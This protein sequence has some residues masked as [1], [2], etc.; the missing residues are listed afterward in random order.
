VPDGPVREFFDGMHDLHHRA[1]WPS[2]RELAKEV[3]C[4]HTTVSVVFSQPSVPRWGLV[5]LIVEA[6]GGDTGR[7]HELWLAASS[8]T[9][10]TGPAAGSVPRQASIPTRPAP[11]PPP[12]QLPGDVTAFTGR[13]TQL[14]ELDRLLAESTFDATA[15]VILAVS[16]TA[17][18][19]KTALAV[20]WAHRVAKAFPDGQLYLNLRGYD[21]ERPVHVAEALERF[22]RA[23]GVEGTA[24]PHGLDERAAQY[25]TLL[26]DRKVLV[27]LDNA[28]SVDQ[29]RDLL[30]G[31]PSCLV[32]ITSRD[33]LPALVAR[34]GA[35][36]IN[37]DVL[38]STEAIELFRRLI[39]ERLDKEPDQAIVLARRCAR[40]PLAIRIAAELAAAR[41]SEPLWRLVAELGDESRRL[42]LLA[43][44]EDDY[45]AVRTVFSWSCRYLSDAAVTVFQLLGLHPGQDIDVDATAAL[46]DVDRTETRRLLEVLSRAHLVAENSPG[47]F[48][49]HDLL[50]AYAAEQAMTRTDQHTALLRLFDHYLR[51]AAR[52][53]E[54]SEAV[55]SDDQWLSAERSNLLAV[56]A[57]AVDVS[58]EHTVK[59]SACLARHLDTG[60]HYSDGVTLHRLALTASRARDDPTGEADSLNRLGFVQLRIGSYPEAIDH[61][62]QALAVHREIGS[63][64]GE[65]TARHGLG[66]VALRLGHC[67]EARDQ[68]EAA[69]TIR[70]ELGDRPGEGTALYGLGNVYRQLGDYQKALDHQ[71][72]ALTIYRECGERIGE[73]RVLNNLGTTMERL[74]NYVQALDHYER[75]LALNREIGNQLGEAVAL[76]NLGWTTARVGRFAEAI[77]H[78]EQAL[79]L[80][81]E[82]GYRVGHADGL[83]G[84]GHV[85]SRM[86]DHNRAMDYL[87]QAVALAHEIGVVDME[88]GALIDLGETRRAVSKHEDAAAAY[89]SALALAEHSGDRYQ[90]ARALTGLAHLNHAAGE[91][92]EAR[93]GWL[94]AAALYDALGVPEAAEVHRLLAAL[95]QG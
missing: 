43:A 33:T 86:G 95:D 54:T 57:A 68:L 4:S 64:E 14:A 61:Y 93:E 9:R 36:R 50:R 29:V 35:V 20:H 16:G 85:Y 56:A 6:L 73:S 76:T 88:T 49:M 82:S 1:G 90:Q 48:G 5:E 72:R 28:H 42:D 30:P 71:H 8:A 60:A 31:T 13:R 53:A 78:H 51:T 94:A 59:L 10:Q 84:L 81:L 34:Y 75:A 2:L 22:L 74:G 3:G 91:L 32:L 87:G 7:F 12:R 25:R 26:A 70:R 92:A 39:G 40:L 83:H 45:T 38:S 24:I 44:G 15:P 23:L 69:L 47:R 18:I 77:V 58:P 52:A 79:P 19:G 21:P 11:S 41:P 46:A 63:L 37:L 67:L 80:Y 55:S 62:R 66:T 27:L 17:G 65:G 89:Q